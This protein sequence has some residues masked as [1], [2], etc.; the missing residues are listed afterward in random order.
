MAR[1][2]SPARDK[3]Y[4]IYKQ[5]KGKKLLKDIASELNVSDAQI[6]KWKNQDKWDDLTNGNVTNAKGNVTKQKKVVIES[7]DLTEK[8]KL[9]CIYY[10]KFFN[11]T[12]AYQK[13]YECAYTT[14]MTNGHGLLR[15]TK[16]ASEIDRMKLDQATE[17]KLD[18]RDVLQKYIDIAFS[19]ITEFL[20]F[21]RQEEIMYNEDG[22]PELDMHGNMKTYAFNYVHLND[23]SDID[24]S[25]VTEVKQGKEGITVK[26]ADKMKA[27]DMLT[28]YF[29]LLSEN[30]KK[31]LQEEKLKTDIVKTNAEIEKLNGNKG[32]GP[33]EII[34]RSKSKE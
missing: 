18:V 12:K 4:E 6:R 9:F 26:L 16:V 5:S 19:D 24:G 29:D 3:A 33:I 31:K 27:L 32:E 1:A 2:R 21:G 10:I 17:L 28:K 7:E 22:D 11:A 8:Q 20:K 34:I 30:D 25:I 23:S 15:N 14:A 13:A